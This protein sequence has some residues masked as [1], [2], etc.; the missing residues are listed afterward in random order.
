[1]SGDPTSLTIS[2]SPPA[3]GVVDHFVVAARPVSGNFYLGR[4]GVPSAS[5]SASYAAA[6]LGITDGSAF[7]VS[8]SA[9]D[10]SGHESLFAYPETRCDATGCV[11]P[12]AAL[13]VTASN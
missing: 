12:P 6:D 4:V 5:T 13:N 2:W 1:V 9:V 7:F 3:D 8:V 10:A 11:V